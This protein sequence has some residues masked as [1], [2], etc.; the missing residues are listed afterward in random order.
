VGEKSCARSVGMSFG[1]R[2][3]NAVEEMEILRLMAVSVLIRIVCMA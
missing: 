2:S 3:V 1:L